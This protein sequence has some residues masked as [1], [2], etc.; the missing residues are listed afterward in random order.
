MLVSTV[1]QEGL[2]GLYRG[3]G[4]TLAGILP[5]AGLKF[6]VYQSLKQQYAKADTLAHSRLHR[7]AEGPDFRSQE[8]HHSPHR[9]PVLVSMSFGAIAGLAAQT[10]TFPLDVVRRQ[11]QVHNQPLCGKCDML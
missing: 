11:M 8:E 2:L 5:Y 10:V 6:Y 7:D 4:P 1:Q 9:L 3:L